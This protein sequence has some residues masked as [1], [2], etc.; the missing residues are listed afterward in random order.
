MSFAHDVERAL[1][2]V[3]DLVNTDPASIGEELLPDPDALQ[4]FVVRHDLSDVDRITDEDLAAVQAIRRR[5]GRY[6][7]PGA[8]KARQSC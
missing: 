6:S 3:V 5:C 8:P 7:S 2:V 1:D 4:A